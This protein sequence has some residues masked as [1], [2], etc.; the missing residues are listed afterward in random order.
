MSTRRLS[1]A[2]DNDS[3]SPQKKTKIT[4]NVAEST[5]LFKCLQESGLKINYPPLKC[6]TREETITIIRNLK[7]NIER[8]YDYPKNVFE[9]VDCFTQE[10]NDLEVFKHYL[11]P[12]I[13]KLIEDSPDEH[14]VNDSLVKILLSVPV[15][16]TKIANYI[17]DKAT[18]LAIE[19]K[20][21]PWIQMM[22]KCFTTLDSVVSSEKMV[23][24]LINLLNVAREKVVRLE[25]IIAIPEMMGDHEHA[26]I[27]NELLDILRTDHELIPAILDSLTYLCLTDDQYK[28]LQKEILKILVELTHSSY[29]PNFIKFLLIPNHGNDG[30]YLPAVQGLR[31]T[32]SWNG[33]GS[34]IQEIATSQVF[35][36][37]AIRNSMISFKPIATAWFK[38]ISN[39]NDHT[40]F[41][42]AILL[43][44]YTTSEERQRQVEN[45]LKKLLKHGNLSENLFRECFFECTPIFREYLPQ[46]I[47]L[48][49][50]LLK[51]ND[52]IIESFAS[53]CYTIM[54][55]EFVDYRQK[56]LA[57]LLQLIL[58]RKHCALNILSIFNNIIMNDKDVLKPH[59]IQMLTLLDRMEDLSL[60]EIRE[61]MNLICG[62]AYS[63]ENSIIKCDVHMII[64]KEL[65]S[66]SPTIKVQGIL[67]GVHAVKY[68]M[69]LNTD[70]DD[71]VEHPD[72]LNY[73]STTHLPE[74][75]IKEA[76]QIIEL[77][78]NSTRQFSELIVFFY[79]E[80]SKIISNAD[81]N[82]NKPF[83]TWLTE[84]VTNDLQQNF[85]VDV[86]PN[87]EIGKLKL[88][89]S[90]GLNTDSEIDEVIAVNIA[91]LTLN[92]KE[93]FNIGI[94]SPLF[95]LVQ[96][97]HSKQHDE[98]L[99][100]IDALLGCPVVMPDFDIDLIEDFEV[101]TAHNIVDCLFY[102]VNWFREI[103]NAFANQ[104][105]SALLKKIFEK[106]TQIQEIQETIAKIILKTK[107]SYKPPSYTTGI[108]KYLME[109]NENKSKVAVK[110]NNLDKKKSND[111]T[112]LPETFKSQATQNTNTV[113]N[114]LEIIQN[115]HFR[116]LNLN[117]L[118]LLKYNLITDEVSECGLNIKNLK[119]LLKCVNCNLGEVL[120]PRIKKTF[121]TKHSNNIYDQNLAEKSIKK[122][123][124]ILPKLVTHMN[125]IFT[126]ID[127]NGIIEIQNEREIIYTEEILDYLTCL[128]YLYDLYSTYLKWNGFKN[129]TN[130]ELISSLKILIG[131]IEIANRSSVS[132][133]KDLY[134][135]TV[136]IFQIHQ[137][138]CLQI[139][140]AMSLLEVVTTIQELYNH[141]V[142]TNILRDMASYIL[143]KEWKTPDGALEKGLHFNQCI[144]KVT[145]LYLLNTNI[146]DLKNMV[147]QIS[148]E[149]GNLKGRYDSLN[150]F[151][152]ITKG[153]FLI[154]YRNL[155]SAVYEAAKKKIDKRVTN[156][157]QLASW[158][159]V[160]TIL[161]YMSDI[162]KRLDNRNILSAF[163]KKSL[164]ILRLF[165]SQ[166]M[167]L[168]ELSFKN[169]TPEVLEII[170]LLQQSTRF[171]QTLC[172]HSRLK[173]DTALMAKV[174]HM[175]KMLETLIYKVKAALA[176]N[177]C[178]EAFWMGNLK[179]RNI[180]GEFIPSQQSTSEESV[181]D[182]DEQLPEDDT[183]DTD[184]EMIHPDSNSIS[185]V[186]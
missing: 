110:K 44:M 99:A 126:F 135:D 122:V 149:I 88:K 94:L 40:Y 51:I 60:N 137:K 35:T 13:I 172:C 155:G 82:I 79:D 55:S 173:K 115:I 50:S 147:I 145:R 66:S 29:F 138:Y 109:T 177:N 103:L 98:N 83:L 140:T 100:S 112:N 17:F 182:C 22:L 15:L 68:L 46:L 75:P 77:M 178:S 102:C 141:T 132:V 116:K 158:K 170:K 42:F 38:T 139:C 56:I 96:T 14:P 58:D 57:E 176:A 61:I 180:H 148:T 154:L 179:I 108:N 93:D 131:T 120:N 160:V 54:L 167:P 142:I 168:I 91:G 164:P 86:I 31:R 19:R 25:V 63:F 162:A 130:D 3:V 171:L 41:D 151:K 125:N 97:L 11:F 87:N 118:T 119:F 161:K 47:D 18:Y 33:C 175:R 24:N 32:L 16:Q 74:G 95:L 71:T 152:S 101:Q 36:A 69:T 185:D 186:I 107:G 26:T 65:G 9:L 89:L 73:S 144:D 127:K 80:L 117:V 37:T 134:L 64:R 72:D 113:K 34:D 114:T 143:L 62:L 48:I 53:F 49:N 1:E 129:Y 7:K 4:K 169:K 174:P 59:S 150:L 111:D 76:A 28:H 45:L 21:G 124:E 128:Q 70:E 123:K 27:A 157:E 181:D 159:D 67:A 90:Y 6:I 136:K 146:F 105:D 10:C 84:A 5:Y 156:S 184:D 12:N 106:I 153:N 52:P 30:D 43:I 104:T 20:C 81:C 85:I 2:D 163:F 183:D 8:H 78:S 165:I 166:G 92:P 121:P 133:I 39:S 23:T